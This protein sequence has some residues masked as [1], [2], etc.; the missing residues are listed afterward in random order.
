MLETLYQVPALVLLL[1]AVA[2]ALVLACGGQVLIHHRF[3]STDFVHH[4]EVGGFIIAVV[5]T[6]YAVLLGFLTT[7]V[8]EHF[9]EAQQHAASESSAAANAWH[10]AVGLPYTVRSRIRSKMNGYAGIM[11]ADEWPAMRRGGFSTKADLALMDAMSAAGDYVPTNAR[12]TN[13]QLVTQEQLSRVHD[14][15][16]RRL[17]NN[18]SAVSWFEWLVLLIGAACVVGF[19]W[20]F[21]VQNAGVHLLMTAAVAIVVVSV[22]VLLFELQYPFRSGLGLQPDAWSSFIE[23]IHLMQNAG[24]MDMRM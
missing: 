14:E 16:Q 11:I 8:W 3:G 10:T 18:D 2:I 6:L 24:Q 1:I 22:L 9:T 12:E 20:L 7:A 23:H 15:R 5:G 19:C 17:T 13:A 4:N 21:G